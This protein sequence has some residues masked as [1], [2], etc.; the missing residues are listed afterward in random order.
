MTLGGDLVRFAARPRFSTPVTVASPLRIEGRPLEIHAEAARFGSPVFICS[1]A[2]SGATA[3]V[4]LAGTVA[5]PRSPS[6][7]YP[8]V[9]PTL[10]VLLPH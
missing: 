4:T 9:V 7:S 6:L 8:R 5:R 3:P 10:G 1:V 2:L